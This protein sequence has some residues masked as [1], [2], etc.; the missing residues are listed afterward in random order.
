[1]EGKFERA[2]R[3]EEGGR[4]GGGEEKRQEGGADEAGIKGESRETPFAMK[5]EVDES[6]ERGGLGWDGMR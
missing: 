3:W 1:L 4:V 2:R 5:N 6:E